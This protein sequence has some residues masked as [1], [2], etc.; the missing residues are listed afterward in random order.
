MPSTSGSFLRA[1]TAKRRVLIVD[2]S[3]TNCRVLE[4]LLYSLEVE[5]TTA[6][7]GHEA[8]AKLAAEP[9]DVVL[10]DV[11]MPDLDGFEVC[12]RI[13][14]DPR[15]QLVPVVLVTA[16]DDRE[17]RLRGIESGADDFITKP[18]DRLELLARMRNF[19]HTR[20]L[21]DQVQRYR[22]TLQ[23]LFEMTSFSAKFADT[24]H[25]LTEFARE[26]CLL[27]GLD[28]SLV[29]VPERAGLKIVGGH[30]LYEELSEGSLLHPGSPESEVSRTGEPLVI[31]A[32]DAGAVNRFHVEPPY[33]GVPMKG[34]DGTILGV[35]SAFGRRSGIEVVPLSDAVR[36]LTILAARLGAEIQLSGMNR[37]L[38][39]LVGERTSALAT[40]L[41]RLTAANAEITQAQEET[42][43]RLALAAEYR[44]EA[45][46]FHVRRMAEYSLEVAREIGMPLDYC[47]VIRLAAP[48]HDIG[49]IGIP[50][51]ILHK[52]GKLTD[53]EFDT[54]RRHTLIGARI[55]SGSSSKVLQMSERIA[56]CHHEKWDGSGYPFGLSGDEIPLEARIVSLADV[57]DAL[58]T[59]R[60][61]KEPFP[62]ERTLAM[63]DEK[64]GNHFDPSLV[65][66]FMQC[67]D[68][69]IAIRDRYQEIDPGVY[70]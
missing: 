52:K 64:R 55:L 12:R 69:V 53:D 48:M 31:M 11:M 35:I 4:A 56:L 32:D 66:A 16:L 58:T 40:A 23:N 57:F 54:M 46:A 33:L 14:S 41:E 29:A 50:D 10:L 1:P 19:L 9:F 21:I 5:T 27:T 65:D 6:L 2:D 39:R 61:Y 59:R 8:L 60:A 18:V 67:L 20:A 42:L 47:D 24:H 22:L 36:V 70:R 30:D 28:Q 43:L 17:N 45:T 15:T 44:D 37:R 26:A 13:K 38:E 51:D 7:G 25:L 62:L 34:Y 63:I 68:R 49:K 3:E